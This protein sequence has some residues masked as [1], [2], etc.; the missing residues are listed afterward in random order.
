MCIYWRTDELLISF[1][2]GVSRRTLTDNTLPGT[3][4]FQLACIIE[5]FYYMLNFNWIF[6]HSFVAS[7]IQSFISG[8]KTVSAL[9]GK[10]SPSG[11]YTSYLNWLKEN[12]S[13]A[14]SC[15]PGDIET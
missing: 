8:S 7:L 14:L 9:N 1:L 3:T 12:G 15:P 13:E 10:L 6:L 5:N 2:E 4:N 11:S